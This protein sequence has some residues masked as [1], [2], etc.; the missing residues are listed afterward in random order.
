MLIAGQRAAR[1]GPALDAAEQIR[2]DF[3]ARWGATGPSWGVAPSTAAVQGYFLLHG[4]TL[5]E[6]ELRTALGLSHRATT[7]AIQECERWGLIT[8]AQALRAGAR[9]PAA[10]AW[11]SVGDHW[12]WFRQV[13]ATRKAREADPVLP[14]LDDCVRRATLADAGDL[15]GRARDLLRFVRQFDRALAVLTRADSPTLAHLF[16]VINRLDDRALDRLLAVVVTVPA[17]ELAL[18]LLNLHRLPS[19]LV[20]RLVH[21]AG[22][23]A[24]NR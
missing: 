6:A 17:D 13:A 23:T 7:I 20:R 18:A 21:F 14:L 19:P 11:T 15:A 16:A 2:R 4:G 3:A 9:G 12:Q 10:R 8:P 5:T 22:H 1:A 24:A